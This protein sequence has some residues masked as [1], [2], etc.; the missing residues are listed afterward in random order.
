MYNR[1][2]KLCIYSKLKINEA[3]IITD[4][5][6]DIKFLGVLRRVRGD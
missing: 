5:F 3:Y 6:V 2:K 1:G 4:V